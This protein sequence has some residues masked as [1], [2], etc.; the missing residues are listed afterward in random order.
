[1]IESSTIWPAQIR[2]YVIGEELGR[3]AFSHVCKCK[4]VKTEAEFAVKIFAKHNLASSGDQARFQREIDTMAY[5]HHD[6]VLALHDFFW[7]DQNFYL[8]V[9]LCPGGELFEY[10]VTHDR[11]D[12]PTA[13]LI[14]QQV[15]SAVAYC[16]SF[17]VAHR[18]L[19]PVDILISEFPSVKVADFGLCGFISEQGMMRTF[20]GSPCY[21]A[22]ECLCRIQYDGRKSDM[23]SLGVILFAMVVGLSAPLECFKHVHHASTDHQR[24]FL[25]PCLYLRR[26]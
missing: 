12:E 3:G 9:D 6:H 1:M 10:S 13:A 4:N 17:G 16:H 2:D 8:I 18:D 26:R 11:L 14:L 19:K 20:C 15:V 21:C 22:P 24:G 25:G 5:I 7:D 23:W